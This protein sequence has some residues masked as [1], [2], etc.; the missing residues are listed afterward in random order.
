MWFAPILTK[1]SVKGKCRFE[2][3]QQTL[4]WYH[5]ATQRSQMTELSTVFTENAWLDT[6]FYLGIQASKYSL[7]QIDMTN[8]KIDLHLSFVWTAITFIIPINWHCQNRYSN[9][10]LG[11]TR[12]FQF[13]LA[14]SRYLWLRLRRPESHLKSFSLS[15]T[16]KVNWLQ[17]TR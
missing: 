13:Y 1:K 12:K 3:N 5:S 4:F 6:K 9:F 8:L 7:E 16:F 10:L 14:L 11:A 17:L 15:N 2:V